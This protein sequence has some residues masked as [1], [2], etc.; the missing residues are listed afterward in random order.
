MFQ[1]NF[2]AK[3]VRR[4]ATE[5]SD[6]RQLAVGLSLGGVWAFSFYFI[7]SLYNNDQNVKIGMKTT[8]S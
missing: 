1:C 8:D 6:K 2:S 4:E 5:W 7:H 3:R